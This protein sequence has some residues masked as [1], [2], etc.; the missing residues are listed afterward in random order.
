[1]K[2]IWKFNIQFLEIFVRSLKFIVNLYLIAGADAIDY[3]RDFMTH[4]DTITHKFLE[5]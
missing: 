5:Q 1:M 3:I 4:S 2:N